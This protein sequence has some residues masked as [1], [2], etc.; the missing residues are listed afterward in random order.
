MKETRMHSSRMRTA[1]TVTGGGG[2]L[3][4]GKE[5]DNSNTICSFIHS[6]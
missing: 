6:L 5:I 1:R 2:I 3:K 4:T